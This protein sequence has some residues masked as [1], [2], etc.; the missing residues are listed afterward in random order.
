MEHVHVFDTQT[1]LRLNGEIPEHT[2][3]AQLADVE[4]LQDDEE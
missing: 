4:A 2:P 3:H 1:G